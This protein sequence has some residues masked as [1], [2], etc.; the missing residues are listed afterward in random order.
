MRV[1]GA[2]TKF[3]EREPWWGPASLSCLVASKVGG[4]LQQLQRRSV[5]SSQRVVAVRGSFAASQDCNQ[6][7]HASSFTT[8]SELD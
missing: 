4:G 7:P 2:R 6:D 3:G 1:G 5:W 8:S